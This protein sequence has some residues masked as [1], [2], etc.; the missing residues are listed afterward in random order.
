MTR[1][2]LT[3]Q[4]ARRSWSAYRP[5][6][7]WQLATTFVLAFL[8]FTVVFAFTNVGS[9][10]QSALPISARSGVDPSTLALSGFNQLAEDQLPALYF[11]VLEQGL[12]SIYRV[13]LTDNVIPQRLST[14]FQV[15]ALQDRQLFAYLDQQAGQTQLFLYSDLTGRVLQLTNDTVT[16][17]KSQ[18]AWS[19]DGNYLAYLVGSDEAARIGLYD[20]AK[21]QEFRLPGTVTAGV[22]HFAWSPDGKTLLFDLWRDEERRVYQMAVPDGEL[23]QLTSFDSW[24]GTWSPDGR[25][26]CRVGARP[27][28]P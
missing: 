8:L 5:S 10:M 18:L 24:G 20:I 9:S 4:V 25:G 11:S 1:V 14:G 21:K 16:A 7:R 17:A 22:S 23:Q 6:R 13:A 2:P 3:M 19:S 15:S 26:D 27:L 28:S 12:P